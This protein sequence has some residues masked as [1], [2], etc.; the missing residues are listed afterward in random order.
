MKH[1]NFYLGLV[2]PSGGWQSLIGL[3]RLGMYRL[4]YIL[5]LWLGQGDQLYWA[6]LFGQPFMQE[7]YNN[8]ENTATI[9][10]KF[11]CI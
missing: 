5:H 8:I 2:L 6:F 11:N 9:V 7:C 3:A 1:S 10:G 4:G